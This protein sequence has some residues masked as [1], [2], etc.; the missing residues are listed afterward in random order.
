[1]ALAK[2]ISLIEHVRR[3]LEDDARARALDLHARLD[4]LE[5]MLSERWPDYAPF[6]SGATPVPG[7]PDGELPS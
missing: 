5:A 1:M 3:S 2:V 6:S 4:R 7:E